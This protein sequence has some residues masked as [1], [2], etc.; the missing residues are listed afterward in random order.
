MD[1]K[2]NF[3]HKIVHYNLADQVHLRKKKVL[4]IFFF[5]LLKK[6]VS[7]YKRVRQQLT[8]EQRQSVLSMNVIKHSPDILRCKC[9]IIMLR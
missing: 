7:T 1:R 4:L 5:I 9:L 2:G 6:I 3:L 8:E